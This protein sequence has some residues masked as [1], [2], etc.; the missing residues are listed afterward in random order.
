MQTVRQKMCLWCIGGNFYFKTPEATVNLQ[1]GVSVYT[2]LES[3]QKN[4]ILK[5][6]ST[7]IKSYLQW[8]NTAS[9][10]HFQDISVFIAALG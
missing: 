2:F 1:R 3:R 7:Q 10:Q 4:F 5:L 9:G 8:D 6:E